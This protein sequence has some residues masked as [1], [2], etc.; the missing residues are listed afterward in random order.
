MRRHMS[1]DTEQLDRLA[2]FD[3]AP[4]PVVSPY[5]NT[6]SGQH[7]RDQHQAFVRSEFKSRSRTYPEGSPERDSLDKDMERITT[8]LETELAPAANGVAIFA[9][10]AGELF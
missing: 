6:Q 8:Y 9:C 7:G 2:Q 5:L 4:Y 1:T 10:S 3:P